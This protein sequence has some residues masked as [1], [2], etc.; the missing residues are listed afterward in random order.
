MKLMDLPR[1]PG[2]YLFMDNSGEIIYIGKA[3]SLRERVRSHFG[4]SNLNSRHIA[5][6]SQVKTVD[7]V[8]AGN[9]KEAL[10]L[11]EKLIKAHSPRYNISFRDDKSYPYLE[12]TTGEK[13]P[14]LKITRKRN[15]GN[16]L[17]FGPFPNVRDL[18]SVKKTADRVF[19]LRKCRKLKENQ[20]PC[21][22]HQIGR[23]LS[24]CA[25]KV[26]EKEYSE[27][28]N[29]L[30]LFLKGDQKKLTEKL[31]EKMEGCKNSL[32][33]EKAA[34]IR[35]QLNEIKRIFPAVNVRKINKKKL[36][37]LKKADPLA[38][39]KHLLNIPQK[40]QIIEG[41]DISH[42]SSDMAVGSMVCF[43]KGKPDKKSYRRYRI[44]QEKTSDDLK[45]LKEVL[46]RR[47]HRL[48]RERKRIPEIIFVDGGKTQGKTARKVLDS[49]KLKHVKVVSLAKK[50]R[51]I[52]SGGKKLKVSEESGVYKLFKRIDDE[53]H[54]FAHSYHKK[55]R[56]K[57]MKPQNKNPE[58]K[59]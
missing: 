47:I 13:F 26:N 15:N 31:R 48:T 9:E 18:R 44:K 51:T 56:E 14:A 35:D 39:L 8:L 16:S 19:Q 42:I 52:Y 38:Q 12:V 41:F 23:C 59:K 2:V 57:K 6:V 27:Y 24:P 25:G 20:R 4:G 21:L 7:F 1:K 43:K 10:I 58:N 50:S 40:P 34:Q 33:Y 46:Y 32:E 11:E 45:M 3:K 53:A 55:R 54:R 22:N 28:V 30:L 49:F 17:Y 5:M 29:E 36:E 37:V